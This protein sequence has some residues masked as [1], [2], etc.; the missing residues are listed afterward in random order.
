MYVWK[1]NT[2]EDIHETLIVITIRVE[3]GVIFLLWA[4]EG[5]PSFLLRVLTTR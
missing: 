2:T 1:N 4:S 3:L 5:F